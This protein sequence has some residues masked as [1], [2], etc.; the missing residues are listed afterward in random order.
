MSRK[1]IN[2][3]ELEIGNQ[4]ECNEFTEYFSGIITHINS[5][6]Q[7]SVIDEKSKCVHYVHCQWLKKTNPSRRDY[8]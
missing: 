8:K 5:E 6:G 2:R 3:K 7:T 4:V 1:I